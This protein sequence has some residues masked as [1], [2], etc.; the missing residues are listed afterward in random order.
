M[1]YLVQNLRNQ[2]AEGVREIR[3]FS[4]YSRNQLQHVE[5]DARRIALESGKPF[6]KFTA[7]TAISRRR[8]FLGRIATFISAFEGVRR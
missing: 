5:K 4:G 1:N 2:I 8:W 7:V 6:L 3:T